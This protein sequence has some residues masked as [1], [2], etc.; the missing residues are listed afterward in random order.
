M[1]R[2][3]ALLINPTFSVRSANERADVESDK[4]LEYTSHDGPS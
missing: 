1:E 3:T 2:L 4:E